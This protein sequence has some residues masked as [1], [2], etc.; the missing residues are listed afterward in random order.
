MDRSAKKED[1]TLHGTLVCLYEKALLENVDT[2]LITCIR[3]EKE[4][5]NELK[6]FCDA[7]EKKCEFIDIFTIM[8]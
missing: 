7:H 2:V 4:V 3:G 5:K 6:S 1:F 8:S